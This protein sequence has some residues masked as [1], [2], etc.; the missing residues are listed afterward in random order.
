MKKLL[1]A[2]SLIGILFGCGQKEK[3]ED[4]PKELN[5]TYVK[6]PLNIPSILGR[7]DGIF[8][9][10]FEKYGTEVKFHELTTGPE[11]IQALASGDMDY[12]Y[13]LSGPSAIIAASNNVP[14][15]ITGVYTR[16]PKVFM[17]ITNSNEIKS[18]KDFIGKKI[19]GPKGTILHQLLVSYLNTEGVSIDDME[20]INM[21]LPNAMSALLNN[22]ADIALLA[23][24]VALNTIKS[25]G[26]VVTTG[27]NLVQ[28]LV[29]TAVRNDFMEKYPKAVEEF[30]KIN[31]E[32][33][34][35]MNNDF[36]NIVDKIAKEVGNTPNEVREMYPLY[37]FNPTITKED[38]KDLEATQEFLL[39]NGLQENKIDIRS[40]IKQ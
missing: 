7:N 27:E 36:E 29:V 40:I 1:V 38:I 13:A 21:G 24:P 34:Q 35:I 26:K 28:G 6:A 16:A 14:L 2:I 9:K 3:K 37:D 25:G 19:V 31:D 33:L 22:S 30:D 15:T 5:M 8:Q 17:I 18:P 32:I 23:G 4:Y 20:F 39:D 11:Q 10:S 12:L